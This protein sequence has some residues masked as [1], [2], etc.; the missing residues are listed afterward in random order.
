[1][2]VVLAY[3]TPTPIFSKNFT[4]EE[5]IEGVG[6]L[7]LATSIKDHH[8]VTIIEGTRPIPTETIIEQITNLEPD[9]LGIS[10]IFSTL[11]INGAKI[12]RE[13]K[14]RL[15]ETKIIFGGNH[16]TFTV[17]ELI[18]EDYVDVVV[19]GEGEITFKE[20][21][22][23]IER[24]LPLDDVR[25]IVFRRDGKT[26]RTAPREPIKDIN[27]IPFPDWRFMNEKMPVSVA[28]CSSRGCPHDCIYCSTTSFWGRKWRSRSA[29]NIIDEINNIFD[30][31][32][33]EKRSLR[34]GFVDDN[35]TVDR[36]RVKRFCHLIHEEKLDLKWGA[37]SRVEFIDESLL[38]IMADAG[39]T[40]LFMGIESGS[41]RVLKLMKRGYSIDEVKEKVEMSMKM[42]I[43]PTCSFMIGNPFEDKSDIEKTLSLLKALKTYRVQVHIFAPLIGTEVF[44]NTEKYGIDILTDK[45]ES[46]N[47]E[48]KAF[49]NTR[50]LKQEE[51]EN[52]YHKC[53]GIVLRRMREEPLVEKIIKV[54][55]YRREIESKA[56]DQILKKAS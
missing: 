35:F 32:K 52:I 51:I 44:K 25:G 53:I 15:P 49:L 43:L 41:E 10:T 23:K 19:M 34:I 14:K 16:A 31:Y 33:P 12:A 28:I 13:I 54:S 22:G 4:K 21:V 11:I 37:S 17:D 39:C 30:V 7:Y 20:L 26:I 3:P 5:K 47:L 36:E 40:G 56:N 2:K 8:D 9:I 1:M 55:R 45:F 24:N 42:G 27:T 46:I 38:E 6:L 50:H 18:K 48:G 29:R